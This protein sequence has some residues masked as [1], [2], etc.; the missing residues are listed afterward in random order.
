MGKP[1]L[2]ERRVL[3]DASLG[4]SAKDGSPEIVPQEPALGELVANITHCLP[5]RVFA[6]NVDEAT[7]LN[8]RVVKRRER[9][10]APLDVE[11]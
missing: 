10:I 1:A 7:I 6:Q 3:V 9:E 2:F 11:A 5:D 8:P 4:A